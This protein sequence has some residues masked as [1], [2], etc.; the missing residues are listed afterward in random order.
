[1]N[2]QDIDLSQ[3]S[4]RELQL[5][6]ARV[7]TC[8]LA[9]VNELAPFNKQANHDS[10]AWYRAVIQSYIDTWGALPS[11]IGPGKDINV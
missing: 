4:T 7:L 5:E 3:M 1:M 9:D 6:A 8:W 11:Q 10:H 2:D